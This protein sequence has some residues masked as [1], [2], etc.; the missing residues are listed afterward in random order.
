ME[1][2]C[3]R[4]VGH[5]MHRVVFKSF[6]AWHQSCAWLRRSEAIIS[7]VLLRWANRS[8]AAALEGWCRHARQQARAQEVCEKIIRRMCHATEAAALVAWR[9]F[10]MEEQLAKRQ[11]EME[12]HMHNLREH[13][14]KKEEQMQLDRDQE[15]RDLA[16]ARAVRFARFEDKVVAIRCRRTC[17][18]LIKVTGL[19]DQLQ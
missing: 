11:I 2:V 13:T 4:V 18:M 6:Q 15:K 9:V 3:G 14:M 16:W 1:D 10:A 5:L 19:G 8:C 17:R 7:R 12:K